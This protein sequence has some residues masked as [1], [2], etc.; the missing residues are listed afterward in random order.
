MGPCHSK[1]K[2]KQENH[3]KATIPHN[4]PPKPQ[5]P[6]VENIKQSINNEDLSKKSNISGLSG[7]FKDSGALNN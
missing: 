2:Q 6:R 7:N 3:I 1:P 5:H 4:S